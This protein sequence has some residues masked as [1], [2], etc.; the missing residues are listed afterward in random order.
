MSKKGITENHGLQ[1]MVFY[2]I[3]L[4]IP[5]LEPIGKVE[6]Q[7]RSIGQIKVPSVKF[8]FEDFEMSV[9]FSFSECVRRRSKFCAIFAVV[10]DRFFTY[11]NFAQE[12]RVRAQA[13]ER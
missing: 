1:K 11:P 4:D 8:V 10:R 3:Q 6:N 13:L 9:P 12:C 2:K 7:P 5:F